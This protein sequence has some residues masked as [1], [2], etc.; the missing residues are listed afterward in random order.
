MSKILVIGGTG[1][2]GRPLV[3]SLAETGHCVSVVCRKNVSEEDANRLA[4]NGGGY[5]YGNSKDST[6]MEG[7]LK[8]HYDAIV[9]FCIYSSEEFKERIGTFL[10]TTDQYVCLSTAAVYADIPTPKNESSPRYMEVDPPQEGSAK[11]NWYCYEKARIEDMLFNSNKRN[12]TI[13]RPGITMNANHI[14]WGNWWDDAWVGRIMRGRKVAVEQDMLDF[15]FSLS[16]GMQVAALIGSIIG[17]PKAMGEVFNVCSGEVW[18]WRGMLET[19]RR[20]F[21]KHGYELKVGYVNSKDVI[22]TNTMREYWYKRARLLNRVFDNA[23][24]RSIIPMQKPEK[25]MSEL[26]E[27]WTDTYIRNYKTC[28]LGGGLVG[29]TA[30]LDRL[31]GDFSARHDFCS[32]RLYFKYLLM[33]HCPKCFALYTRLCGSVHYV[34]RRICVM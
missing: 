34:I 23:K 28:R 4:G 10:G 1:N 8:Q 25:S 13:V 5:Y 9:D 31:T 14:G 24:I 22:G 12:W 20:I 29:Q 18:S 27:E 11:R 6:F 32:L 19:Y 3:K 7:V 17:N 21:A 33:R 16:S 30:E 26:L 2:M 15:K